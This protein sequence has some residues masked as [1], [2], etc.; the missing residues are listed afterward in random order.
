MRWPDLMID[1]FKKFFLYLHYER[2]VCYTAIGACC[3]QLLA[4]S[5]T[6]TIDAFKYAC[7]WMS[8]LLTDRRQNKSAV[9]RFN[10]TSRWCL[11]WATEDF[12]TNWIKCVSFS[13]ESPLYIAE[14]CV[15]STEQHILAT[16][17]MA[18]YCTN[19]LPC[20]IAVF[21]D[22]TI[23]RSINAETNPPILKKFVLSGLVFFQT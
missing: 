23:K 3:M 22:E 4:C 13:G 9:W 7:E 6:Y 8:E 19:A 14:N 21:R 15:Y 1:R 18:D 10:E 12:Y 16:P 2:T 5:Q 17:T 20:S 11:C